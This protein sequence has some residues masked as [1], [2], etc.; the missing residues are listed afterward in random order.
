MLLLLLLVGDTVIRVNTLVSNGMG[1]SNTAV[2][3]N[4]PLI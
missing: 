4:V 1:G 2:Q 3:G